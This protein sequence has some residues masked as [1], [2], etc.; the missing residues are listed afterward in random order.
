MNEIIVNNDKWERKEYDWDSWFNFDRRPIGCRNEI[1]KFEGFNISYNPN[2]CE[3]MG[4]FEGESEETAIVVNPTGDTKFYILN[5]DF[6]KEYKEL[7]INGINACLAFFVK[8]QKQHGCK[9]GETNI[10]LDL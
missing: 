3:G 7:A 9:W 6:R 8:N 1:M 5:G 10:T 4:S 2:P